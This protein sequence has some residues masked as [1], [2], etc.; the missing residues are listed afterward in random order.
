MVLS[1]TLHPFPSLLADSSIGMAGTNGYVCGQAVA[2]LRVA[3]ASPLGD[4]ST[5]FE[6]CEMWY[7]GGVDVRLGLLVGFARRRVR[8]N[9]RTAPKNAVRLRFNFTG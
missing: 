1:D 5:T 7:L 2:A 6:H 3:Q 9:G 8:P 4:W